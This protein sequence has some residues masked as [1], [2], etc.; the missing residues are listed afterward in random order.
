MPGLLLLIVS[1]EVVPTEWAERAVDIGLE[2]LDEPSALALVA[3][4]AQGVPLAAAK[5]RQIIERSGGIPLFVEELARSA[6]TSRREERLPLRLQELLAARLKAPG[7]DL[8]LAQLAAT[9]GPV[10]DRI[11]LAEH[12]QRVIQRREEEFICLVGVPRITLDNIE[13]FRLVYWH[14]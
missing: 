5:Q 4:I 2:P 6:A 8:R 11:L 13:Q 7:I 12:M 10:F 3:E 9:F 14:S 1:R